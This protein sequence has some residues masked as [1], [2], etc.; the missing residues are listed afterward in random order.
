MEKSPFG[1][2]TS[3]LRHL[4]IGSEDKEKWNFWEDLNCLEY[5]E[6]LFRERCVLHK[7][8]LLKNPNFAFHSSGIQIPC[9][10]IAALIWQR[11][12][13]LYSKKSLPF[14][15]IWIRHK[16]SFH[17]IKDETIF[18]YELYLTV[19]YEIPSF[20]KFFSIITMFFL[21][22]EEC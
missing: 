12:R 17:S 21:W 16:W 18:R 13:L 20:L 4:T 3:L 5:M 15:I 8:R 7:N 14:I 9:I 11:K 6:H 10:L 2:H 19:K 1:P 22:G